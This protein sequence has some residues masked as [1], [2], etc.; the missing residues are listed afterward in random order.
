MKTI[1]RLLKDA[2]WVLKRPMLHILFGTLLAAVLVAVISTFLY[3]FL[4]GWVALGLNLRQSMFLLVIFWGLMI[5]I[6]DAYIRV[7]QKKK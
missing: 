6:A 2:V 3:Y 7:K 1:H 5:W 4:L